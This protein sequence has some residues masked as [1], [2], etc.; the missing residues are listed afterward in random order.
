MHRL[1]GS[2]SNPLGENIM[3]NKFNETITN[4]ILEIFQ[5]AKQVQ[6]QLFERP[7]TIEIL[8]NLK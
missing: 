6:K 2:D 7:A 4:E 5:F 8:G 1:I 3:N